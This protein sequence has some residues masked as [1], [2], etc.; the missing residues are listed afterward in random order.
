M[1][2]IELHFQILKKKKFGWCCLETA[3]SRARGKRDGAMTCDS[4]VRGICLVGKCEMCTENGSFSSVYTLYIM[5]GAV[6][7]T[8]GI[9]PKSGHLQS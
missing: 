5:M 2:T 3:A 4:M 6:R 8:A 1:I 9:V 7:D